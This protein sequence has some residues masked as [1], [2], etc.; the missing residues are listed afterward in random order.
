MTA[1]G[2][3]TENIGRLLRYGHLFPINLAILDIL[4]H[5][6]SCTISV[7]QVCFMFHETF[8]VSRFMKNLKFHFTCNNGFT[9]SLLSTTGSRSIPYCTARKRD[10]R[11][12]TTRVF[13]Y[14]GGRHP[15]V[16]SLDDIYGRMCPCTVHQPATTAQVCI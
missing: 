16:S 7:H 3:H 11:L 4:Q 12:L 8:L 9:S 6:Y 14:S 15:A 2:N 5:K 1:L 10:P 13:C